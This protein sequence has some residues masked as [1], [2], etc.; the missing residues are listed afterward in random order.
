MICKLTKSCLGK[1]EM[2]DNLLV[3]LSSS[4]SLAGTLSFSARE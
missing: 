2:F 1:I 3:H 4:R